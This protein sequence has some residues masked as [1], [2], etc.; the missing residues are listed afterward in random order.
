MIYKLFSLIMLIPVMLGIYVVLPITLQTEFIKALFVIIYLLIVALLLYIPNEKMGINRKYVKDSENMELYLKVKEEYNRSFKSLQTRLKKKQLLTIIMIIVVIVGYLIIAYIGSLNPLFLG[1][2]KWIKIVTIVLIFICTA[3]I[4]PSSA[5]PKKYNA[6]YKERIVRKIIEYIDPSWEYMHENTELLNEYKD[7]NLYDKIE[8]EMIVIDDYISGKID[9]NMSIKMCNMKITC[10]P[11]KLIPERVKDVFEG[12]FVDAVMSNNIGGEIR[13]YSFAY[14]K[15]IIDKTR[16]KIVETDSNEFNELFITYAENQVE[17]LQ[18]LTAE[19]MQILMDFYA[20]TNILYDISIK[21]N[22]IYIK[23]HV[24]KMFE[25][26]SMI[27]A[28]N[29]RDISLYNTIVHFSMD[30]ARKLNTALK[31]VNL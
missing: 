11:N 28:V 30:I 12:M 31:T 6:V 3:G 25:P 8:E 19:V 29:Y 1:D 22:H 17:A 10:V 2:T 24:G 20:K 4:L 9:N 27:N 7:S 13:L 5:I 26:K 21:N 18:V 23:L 16:F 15:N 14:S